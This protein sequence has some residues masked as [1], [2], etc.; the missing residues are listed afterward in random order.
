MLT[1]FADCPDAIR[2][3]IEIADRCN[4]ELHFGKHQ[5]PVYAVPENRRLEDY[6]R[7]RCRDGLEERL[8]TLLEQNPD[9]DVESYRTRLEEE[10]ETI[11]STGFAGYFLI[12]ADFVNFAKDRGIPV[13]PGRGSAAGS[14]VSYALKITDIDPI[15]YN[16]L[17][18]RFLN[19]ERVTMPDIDIDF[20]YERRDEV[21]ALCPR[22]IR[23]RPGRQHHHV[24]NIEGKGRDPRRRARAR[25]FVHGNRSHLQALPGPQAGQ[26]LHA[27]PSAGDRAQDGRDPR[28]RRAGEETL[29]VC[30]QAR[31]I[32]AARIEARRRHR[33]LGQA[34][35]RIRTVVRRQR[36]HGDDAI[37]RTGHRGA[38]ARQVRFSGAENPH[39]DRRHRAPHPRNDGRKHRRVHSAA[40]RRRDLPAG[41][42]RPTRSA[43]SRW[44]AGACRT[45]SPRSS[46]R[47]S[48]T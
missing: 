42:A 32:G 45:C 48:R 19:P 28:R 47:A 36:R 35:R 13:G 26:G 4:V 38:R 8:T 25:L 46:R 12:V 21:D 15:R 44:R 9:L 33:H 3:S 17:F 31:R 24:R 1:A 27:R 34:S 30:P 5:F 10:I 6:L 40:R 20:C 2:T 23:A 16:L 39:R 18:E 29:R 41:R 37:R 14:L 22:K 11:I 7:D 43:S